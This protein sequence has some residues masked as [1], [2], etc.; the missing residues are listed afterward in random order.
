MIIPKLRDIRIDP[1][2]VDPIILLWSILQYPMNTNRQENRIYID[3]KSIFP[4][5][6]SKLIKNSTIKREHIVP[7]V[8]PNI[9]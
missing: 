5:P 6:V 1:I 2:R 7:I 4:Y 9:I 3:R 8:I